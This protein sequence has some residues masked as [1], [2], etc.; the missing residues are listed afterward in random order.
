MSSSDGKGSNAP[1]RK[2][3]RV[4]EEEEGEQGHQ[5][6]AAKRKL[7]LEK[8]KPCT[9]LIESCSGGVSQNESLTES[10]M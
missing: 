4:L 7:G 5:E 9:C 6:P 2:G 8:V 10:G 1:V 3:K